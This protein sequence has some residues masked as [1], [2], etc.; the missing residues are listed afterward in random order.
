VYI[1]LVDLAAVASGAVT[2]QLYD[3]PT[4]R[5]SDL[6]AGGSPVSVTLASPGQNAVLGFS[7]QA[8]QRVSLKVGPSCCQATVTIKNPDG[9][10]LATGVAFT[11]GGFVDT[12]A[13]PQSG[14]D[15]LLLHPAPP[16]PGPL[17]P[18]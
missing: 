9:S 7:G 13:L 5:S 8:G 17:T 15:T 2:R 14:A 12:K 10:T 1:I 16:A 6:V 11:S 3:L 4:R 18:Q